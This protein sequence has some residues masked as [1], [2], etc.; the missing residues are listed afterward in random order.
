MGG[1]GVFERAR[2]GQADVFNRHA[3]QPARDVE[4]VFARFEHSA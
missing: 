1:H 3:H 2:V 4:P